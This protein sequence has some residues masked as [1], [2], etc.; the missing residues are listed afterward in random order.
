MR[1]TIKYLL[2]F[3]LVCNS[4]IFAQDYIIL[5]MFMKNNAKLDGT[6][7]NQWIIP[8]D[9]LHNFEINHV[10]PLLITDYSF[11]N[12]EDCLKNQ[13]IDPF[14]YSTQTNFKFPIGFIDSL[15]NNSKKLNLE[16]RLI[17]TIKKKWTNGYK[18][19][20]K[21]YA[22]PVKGEFCNCDLY[23]DFRNNFSY[24]GKIYLGTSKILIDNSFWNSEI[25]STLKSIDFSKFYNFNRIFN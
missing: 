3:T 14:S 7:Y 16:K 4:E 10:Y 19:K 6:K 8:V 24:N 22:I 25:S 18:E 5:K 23:V 21:I 9:S 1:S 15:N 12:L 20:V 2:F 13:K 17:Q 11:D